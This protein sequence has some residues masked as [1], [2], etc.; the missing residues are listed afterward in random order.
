VFGRLAE[1]LERE[2]IEGEMTYKK[3]KK[4]TECR[5]FTVRSFSTSPNPK[6]EDHPFSAVHDCLLN[7][8]AATFHVG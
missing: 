8:F 5:V 4:N 7:I 1:K 2:N 6:L 3:Y